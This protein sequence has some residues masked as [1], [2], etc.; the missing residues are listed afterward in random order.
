MG[1]DS[2]VILREKDAEINQLCVDN[3][4]LVQVVKALRRST[5]RDVTA[6]LSTKDSP[7]V[8]RS[9]DRGAGEHPLAGNKVL[10]QK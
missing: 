10:E 7:P 5:T 6:A 8:A 1:D 2:D 3:A 9:D 4:F